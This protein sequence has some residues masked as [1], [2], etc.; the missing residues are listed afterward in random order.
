MAS[1]QA[2][3]GQPA[4]VAYASAKAGLVN[5]TR[6]LAIDLGGEGIR[7]N[8]VAPGFIDTRMAITPAGEHEHQTAAFRGF[9]L[10]QGRIPL[11]RAGRPEDVADVIVFLASD[12]SRYVTGQV[13]VVDGG[14]SATY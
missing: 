12:L 13:I 10:D 7:A 6:C 2:L 5:F 9:Y 8:A 3:F 4:S 14:L 11:R 1:T